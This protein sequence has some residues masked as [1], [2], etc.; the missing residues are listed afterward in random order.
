M[1]PANDRPT[2]EPATGPE[3]WRTYN[4]DE[5]PPLFGLTFST[6]IWNA[7]FVPAGQNLFLLVTLEK[8]DMPDDHNYEDRFLTPERLEWK[9]QNRTKQASKHGQMLRYH[10][11]Q[12]LTVHL[13][14]RRTKKNGTKSAPFHYCGPVSFEQWRDECPIT[15]TWRMA[16]AVPERLRKLFGIRSA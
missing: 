14:V 8:G 11:E 4:R 1:R 5:I 3:L 13:F 9:S 10:R 12:N 15:I 6:A 7:G 16:T 2:I